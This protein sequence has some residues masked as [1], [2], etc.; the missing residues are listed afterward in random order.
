MK[1]TIEHPDGRNEQANLSARDMALI[2]LYLAYDEDAESIDWDA[3][4]GGDAG[5]FDSYIGAHAEPDPD[6]AFVHARETDALPALREAADRAGLTEENLGEKLALVVFN[7]SRHG[8][9]VM[10]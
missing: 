4:A 9:E 1:V 5:N 6:T 10:R 3:A 8:L 2:A 7:R